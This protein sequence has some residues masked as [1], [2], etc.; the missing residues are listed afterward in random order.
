MTDAAFD[1]AQVRAFRFT[2]CSFDAAAGEA[3]LGYAF[4]DMPEMVEAIRF[5]GAPFL[6]DAAR[7][8]AVQR[9][10]RLLHLVAGISYY[11]AAV[12]ERIEIDGEGID[13]ATA[14]LLQ[15]TY[16]H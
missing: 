4:D 7:A 15:S 10:L 13:A 5:P 1:P 11:K 2:A 3:R 9:A 8:D 16:E 12:P 14:A 6:L